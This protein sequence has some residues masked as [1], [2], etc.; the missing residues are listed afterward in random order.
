[1]GTLYVKGELIL[2]QNVIENEEL[3]R[4]DKRTMAIIKCV[5]NDIQSD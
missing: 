1:M 2:D 4:G 3:I 5:G